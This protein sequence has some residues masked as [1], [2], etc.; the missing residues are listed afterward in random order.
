MC[1]RDSFLTAHQD[2]ALEKIFFAA[3]SDWDY[4]VLARALN[5]YTASELGVRAVLEPFIDENEGAA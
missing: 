4:R 5:R 1:I 2:T 3:Y